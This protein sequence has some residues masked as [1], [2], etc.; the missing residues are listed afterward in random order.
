[1]SKIR[2]ALI[3]LMTAF[4]LAAH[5][6]ITVGDLPGDTVWYLHA[7]LDAMRGSDG[8]SRVYRWLEDELFLEINEEIGI[9]LNAEVHSVTAFAAADNGTVIVVDGPLSRDTQDKIMALAASQ[10][11]VDPRDH[12]SKVYYFFGDDDDE[13]NNGDDPLKDL[14]DSSY[15]SFAVKGKAIITANENQMRALLDNDGRITGMG[16]HS[17]ALLVLSANKSL[18]QAG[19]N[20]EGMVDEDDDDDW[21]SNIMRNT[22]QAA[23]LVADESGMLAIEAQLISTDPKMAEAIGGIVN[24]LIG[25]QAFNADLSPELRD[26]IRNTRVDVRDRTLSIS[27]VLDPDVVVSVLDE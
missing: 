22:E 10:G 12:K 18:V 1:M 17:G 24:G 16:S 27:T 4:P 26:F 11:P 6:D 14:E 7:D 20:A 23:M 19:M 9:D 3:G 15:V 2:L 25:L 8:G 13:G 21:E 5:A